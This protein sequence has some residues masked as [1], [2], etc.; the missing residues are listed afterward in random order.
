MITGTT[1]E[2]VAKIVANIGNNFSANTSPLLL[3]ETSPN[4]N[5]LP[6]GDVAKAATL[7]LGESTSNN[8]LKI[9]ERPIDDVAK[10]ALA[11]Y[12]HISTNM[13]G[14]DYVSFIPNPIV[15]SPELYI[16][17]QYRVETFLGNYGAGETAKTF[18]LLPGERT[19]IS[20]TSYKKSEKHRKDISNILDSFNEESSNEFENLIQ[21]ETSSSKEK[22]RQVNVGRQYGASA[23]IPLEGVMVGLSSLTSLNASARTI[24]KEAI[25][26]LNK[27]ISKQVQKST[28]NR[29]MEVNTE[30]SQMD[31]ESEETTTTR[32][33]ENINKSRVLNFVFRQLNQE[34]I[35]VTYLE[36]VSFLFINGYQENVRKVGLSGL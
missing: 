26:K 6:V 21:D 24:K 12:P 23:T 34:L 10:N 22:D 18:S 14:R 32:V 8:N 29:K 27:S 33:L 2:K 9:G 19:T 5:W 31:T 20:V 7:P 28:S 1:E 35:T 3:A 11:G 16:V 15:A 25:K 13:A 30:T 36:N 17:E 4:P